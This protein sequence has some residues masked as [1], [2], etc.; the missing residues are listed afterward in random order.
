MT[1][2]VVDDGPFGDLARHFNSAWAWP[3]STLCIVE[4]VALATTQDRSGRRAQ[5]LSMR[6][7]NGDQCVQIESVPVDSAAGE[8]LYSY[9]RVQT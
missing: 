8:F 9:L 1:A 3:G 4:E 2:W 6:A 5:L 7:A